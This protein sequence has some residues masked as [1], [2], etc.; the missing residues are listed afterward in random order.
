MFDHLEGE[1]LAIFESRLETRRFAAGA[2]LMAQ[3][4]PGDGCYLIDEGIV[5]L[6]IEI[7]EVDTDGVLGYLEPGDLLGEFSLLDEEPRSASAYAHTEVTAR[8]LSAEDFR[9]LCEQHPRLGLS[10][11]ARF[12]RNLSRKMRHMNERL[13]HYISAESPP[14]SVQKMIAR[15]G[16]AQ[17]AFCDWPE[18]KVD[19]LIVAIAET[20]SAHAEELAEATVRETRIGVVADKVVK[21]RLACDE[22]SRALVGQ[23]AAGPLGTDPTTGITELA[24]P[25][26]VVLGLI[27]LTNPVPTFV[28][29]VMIALKSRNALILSCHHHAL[30]VGTRVGELIQEVL[31]VH[32]A[33]AD[34]VQW[35]RERSSR[36]RTAM[37]M[38]HEGV[39]FILATGG[40]GMVRAAYSSGT[41][42]IGVGPGNAPVLV[43]ADADVAAAAAMIVASKS[44]DNGV[45]CGSDNN[46]IA[47]EAIADD[48][49]NGLVANGAVI[50]SPEERD[51]LAEAVVD[52][53][54]GHLRREVVGQSADSILARAGIVRE[55]GARLIVLPLGTDMLRHPF[56]R[57]KLAPMVSFFRVAGLEQGFALCRQILMSEG[58]GHTAIIHT[59]DDALAHRYGLDMPASRVLVNTGGSTGCIGVGNGLTPSFTLSCGTLGGGS[60]TDNVTF[61]HLLNIKRLARAI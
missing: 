50:L 36:V 39:A 11:M 53:G 24:A 3:G 21:I 33:P 41:P 27:P 8:W 40:P 15:S 28:F 30:G 55:A 58:Q 56:A 48:L 47:V 14:P 51:R 6:E 44:F 2:C 38:M 18:A 61:R 4:G 13:S 25:M 31:R 52:P 45:I 60:T 26:G 46:I 54:A 10:I 1:D 12:G 59:A 32:G 43:C 34:L 42:A 29:K 16:A 5:R 57:E 9:E 17:H 35:I 22:V 49:A 20:V 19:A 37:Y 7:G 23:P